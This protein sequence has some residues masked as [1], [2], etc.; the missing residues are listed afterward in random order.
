MYIGDTIT[1]KV[2]IESI[3]EKG[4]AVLKTQVAKSTGETVIDGKGK[5][6]LPG[7]SSRGGSL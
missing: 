7:N 6:I 3:D 2:V 4:K 1:A 5:V